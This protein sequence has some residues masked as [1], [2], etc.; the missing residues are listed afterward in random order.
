MVDLSS[1]LRKRL[2]GRVS[3]GLLKAGHDSADSVDS[4]KQWKGLQKNMEN[5]AFIGSMCYIVLYSGGH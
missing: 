1:S 5:V 4:A 2:P 3:L